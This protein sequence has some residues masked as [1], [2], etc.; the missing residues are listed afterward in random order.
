M[1]KDNMQ[2]KEKKVVSA[3]K[4][5]TKK[6][7]KDKPKR[8]LSAYNYFF[9]EERE[10]ILKTLLGD[11]ANNPE[12]SPDHINDEQVKKL[13]KDGG[14]VSFEEMGKLIGQRWKAIS[15]DRLTKY[16]ALAASDTE[17]YKKE[18]ECYNGR[19]EERL[20]EEPTWD[21][22]HDHMYAPPPHMQ[23]RGPMPP[24]PMG[25]PPRYPSDPSV[26]HGQGVNMYQSSSGYGQH[27]PMN[28]SSGYM[29]YQVEGGGPPPNHGYSGSHI[30]Q[31]M[32]MGAYHQYGSYPQ[33]DGAQNG[34]QYSNMAP[35]NVSSNS[36]VPTQTPNTNSYMNNSGGRHNGMTS[37]PPGYPSTGS[38]PYNSNNTQP[39]AAD[40]SQSPSDNRSNNQYQYQSQASSYQ[41]YGHQAYSSDGQSGQNW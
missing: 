31:S 26:A 19:R 32:P 41:S 29:P 7:P 1:V 6:K 23:G 36:N 5:P 4:R 21:G 22:R 11:E 39:A 37:T 24:G 3:T 15:Q 38:V 40:Y 12:D 17:R 35:V 2:P 20:R 9:K 28:G 13:K 33:M 27:V 30:S 10:K 14:K 25:Q 18:M 8:P 34:H 16:T